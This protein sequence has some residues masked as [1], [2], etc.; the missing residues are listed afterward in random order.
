MANNGI[1]QI[2]TGVLNPNHSSAFHPIRSVMRIVKKNCA[3]N[4]AYFI[5]KDG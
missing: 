3:P 5:S 2:K 1:D 4:P